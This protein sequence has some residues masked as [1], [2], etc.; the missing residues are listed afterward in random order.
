MKKIYLVKKDPS[1]E[2]KDNWIVMSGEEFHDFISTAEGQRRKDSFEVLEACSEDDVM[3]V[4]ECGRTNASEWKRDR[5]RARY[6]RNMKILGD[7][8]EV[9]LNEK[10]SGDED[11]VYEDSIAS[12][13]EFPEDTVIVKMT[14]EKLSVAILKLN[15][16]ER[17]MI[18][19]M[20]LEE[21]HMSEREYAEY[22]HMTR[23]L[24]NRQKY[25]VLE[26]LKRLLDL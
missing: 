10:V 17:D 16:S 5:D 1:A 18:N 3:I 7:Y 15:D 25:R 19:K 26:K 13:D 24:V 12:P 4:A 6:T 11:L 8:I 21:P 23:A 20:F 14:K 9:G 22:A 2:A